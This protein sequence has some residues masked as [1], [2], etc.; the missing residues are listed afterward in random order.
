VFLITGGLG[1]VSYNFRS[2]PQ[3]KSKP[4]AGVS[5][6]TGGRQTFSSGEGG[7]LPMATYS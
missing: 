6:V 4:Y 7:Q 1:R 3:L 2:H 5:Y